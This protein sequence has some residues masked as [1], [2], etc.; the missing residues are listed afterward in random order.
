MI[1]VCG[2]CAQYIVEFVITVPQAVCFAP[3]SAD[4]RLRVEVSLG[5]VLHTV[6]IQSITTAGRGN[7]A[8]VSV[9]IFYSECP[10]LVV[11]MFV[12]GNTSCECSSSPDASGY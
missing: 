5:L 6:A 7:Q 10:P 4:I 11:F 1:F 12:V 2:M 9:C 8:A 3:G